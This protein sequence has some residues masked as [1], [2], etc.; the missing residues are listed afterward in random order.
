[1]TSNRITLRLEPELTPVRMDDKLDLNAEIKV[2]VDS[3]L[4]GLGV[5]GLILVGIGTVLLLTGAFLFWWAWPDQ[6]N[7]E[8][9]S[10]ARSRQ[11]VEAVVLLIG[12]GLTALFF[13]TSS[14]FYG[15]TVLGS[16]SLDAFQMQESLEAQR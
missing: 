3:H 4:T 8:T 13:G 15:R 14:F 16:G 12:A 11:L 1:M 10:Y 6:W 7:A 5:F 9:V 2:K